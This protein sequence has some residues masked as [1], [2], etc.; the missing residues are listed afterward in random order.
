MLGNWPRMF[1]V[2]S[3]WHDWFVN[4]KINLSWCQLTGV[5]IDKQQSLQSCCLLTELIVP[6]I[7]PL[8]RAVWNIVQSYVTVKSLP[9][10]LLIDTVNK[11]RPVICWT[12]LVGQQWDVL[13]SLMKSSRWTGVF[14]L[15]KFHQNKKS[16]VPLFK[17]VCVWHFKI[18]T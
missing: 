9:F 4:F 5:N 7:L 3:Q 11:S 16:T 12:K 1:T 17:V 6:Q 2:K 14:S 15:C 8:V 13:D 10:W 18:S